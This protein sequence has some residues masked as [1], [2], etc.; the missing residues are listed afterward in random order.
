MFA[1]DAAANVVVV[2]SVFALR[3]IDF[4][5]PFNVHL[6]LM[7]QINQLGRAVL[8]TSSGDRR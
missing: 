5:Q 6:M 3:L 8:I 2:V 1:A 4:V 7:H